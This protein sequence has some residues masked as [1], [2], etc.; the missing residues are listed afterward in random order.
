MFQIADCALDEEDSPVGRDTAPLELPFRGGKP[1]AGMPAP[2]CK[3]CSEDT[4]T[5][6]TPADMTV[7]VR[8]ERER[9]K[10]VDANL[11]QAN[12]KLQ[13]VE[14]E[15]QK[16]ET[17]RSKLTGVICNLSTT[18]FNNSVTMQ[19]DSELRKKLVETNSKQQ[20]L[21]HDA[22]KKPTHGL[23]CIATSLIITAKVNIICIVLQRLFFSTIVV[24]IRN[25]I[26]V[27]GT[28]FS[29]NFL[30]IV[31]FFLAV[32]FF[33]FMLTASP[34]PSAS[35]SEFWGS[36]SCFYDCGLDFGL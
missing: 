18:T 2:I 23:F 5:S 4:E 1:P 21:L 6:L 11:K 36:L 19:N 25:N 28:I 35:F 32:A 33:L 9:R 3:S 22:E 8:R 24:S 20:D 10:R 17:E 30:F 31:P 12:Q 13:T 34:L 14:K 26:S 27:S 7:E 29:G 15:K 16:A